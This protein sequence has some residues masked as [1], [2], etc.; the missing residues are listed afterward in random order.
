MVA[1]GSPK[2]YCAD[3]EKQFSF[4]V[5]CFRIA[6]ESVKEA[7]YRVFKIGDISVLDDLKELV[8]RFGLE[9]NFVSTRSGK[10]ITCNRASRFFVAS[11]IRKTSTIVSGCG[12]LVRF[13]AVEWKKCTKSDPVIIIGVCGVHS[14]TCNPEL[15]D[16]FVLSRTRAG[17]Y[18][19]CADHSLQEVIVQ[20]CIKSFVS[21]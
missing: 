18:K 10:T 7:F 5:S 11:G 6:D 15:V 2:V 9:W 16:Q 1:E 14:N 20:I 17:I 3:Y 21:V 19:K 4:H 12:W 13:R 8:R